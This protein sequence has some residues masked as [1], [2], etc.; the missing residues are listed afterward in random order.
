MDSQLCRMACANVKEDMSLT[1]VVQE[2]LRLPRS[3][4]LMSTA[5][6]LFDTFS[7]LSRLLHSAST[8][9]HEVR[10]SLLSYCLWVLLSRIWDF[11]KAGQQ[12]VVQE[13]RYDPLNEFTTLGSF[14]SSEAAPIMRE[15]V[16]IVNGYIEHEFLHCRDTSRVPHSYEIT[17]TKF[18]S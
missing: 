9:L 11:W 8:G 13:V 14:S 15:F 10:A 17:Q 5:T 16:N 6:S 18:L 12:L 1:R 4:S 7:I 2:M 3:S